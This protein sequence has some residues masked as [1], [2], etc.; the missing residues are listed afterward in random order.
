MS[1]FSV[2][3]PLPSVEHYFQDGWSEASPRTS[4]ELRSRRSLRWPTDFVGGPWKKELR[5]PMPSPRVIRVLLIAAGWIG[6][7]AGL[8]GAAATFGPEKAVPVAGAES[9]VAWQDPSRPASTAASASA[10]AS[11][12]AA[13]SS[14]SAADRSLRTPGAETAAATPS[15]VSSSSVGSLSVASPS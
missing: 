8:L 15:A 1:F 6:G 11:A 9:A 12:A 3:L 2:T 4:K 10:S 7:T 5:S 14:L 13:R